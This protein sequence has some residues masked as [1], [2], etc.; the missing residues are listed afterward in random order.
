MPEIDQALNSFH[1]VNTT[2]ASAPS[3]V[4]IALLNQATPGSNSSPLDR[5]CGS[6]A[7]MRAARDLPEH[8]QDHKARRLAHVI[9]VGLESHAEHGGWSCRAPIPLRAS[10]MRPAMAIL[11]SV[12]TFS[13]CST[14]DSGD[15]ASRAVRISAVT[16]L[17]KQ[18]PP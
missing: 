5:P 16:S 10:S 1:S 13:T 3:T 6:Q 15:F 18:E 4:S 11:R 8:R 7:L 12:F 14:S 17:G 2:R 9:G